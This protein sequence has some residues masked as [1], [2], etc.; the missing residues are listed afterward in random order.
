M[1]VDS[2]SS[3]LLIDKNLVEKLEILKIKLAHSKL[4]VNADHSMNDR[5]THVVCLDIRIGAVRDSVVFVIAN[6][7]KAGAFLGFDWLE[8]LNPIIDWKR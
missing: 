2:S 8:H 6:L 1:L 5:I 7:S 4:L 3:G